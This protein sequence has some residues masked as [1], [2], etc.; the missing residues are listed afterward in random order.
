MVLEANSK[1]CM[2]NKY[3]ISF[4]KSVDDELVK[5]W[6][7]KNN[8]ARFKN[9]VKKSKSALPRRVV[10][11]YLYFCSEERPKIKADHPEM[12][13]K[14]ITCELGRRWAAFQADPDEERLARITKCFEEDKIR[15]EKAKE[16]CRPDTKKKRVVSSAYMCYCAAERVKNK[17]VTM[18][19]LGEGWALIKSDPDELQKY[20]NMVRVG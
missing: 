6:K 9:L 7:D 14:A 1:F 13:I 20:Q 8:Q 15:Y 2:I 4:L 18:K 3:V 12:D 19:Q 11:K 10:S 17:T 5:E 16:A